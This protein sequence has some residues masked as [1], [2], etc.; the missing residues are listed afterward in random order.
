L[1]VLGRHAKDQF[2]R[3]IFHE[4][5]VPLNAASMAVEELNSRGE[6][7]CDDSR[8]LLGD[9]LVQVCGVGVTFAAVSDPAV[10]VGAGSSR[11]CR[12]S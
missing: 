4:L 9:A 5:R 7:F 1:T 8:E 11:P 3:Y 10:G 2:L 12:A 6:P